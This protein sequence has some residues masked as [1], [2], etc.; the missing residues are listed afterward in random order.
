VHL[1]AQDAV[2]R[3]GAACHERGGLSVNAPPSPTPQMELIL[4]IWWTPT[5]LLAPGPQ[6]SSGQAGTLNTFTCRSAHR[7][8]R[9]PT[10]L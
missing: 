3:G 8:V 6:H 2:K 4:G 7:Q 5:Q 10:A 1:S 9:D